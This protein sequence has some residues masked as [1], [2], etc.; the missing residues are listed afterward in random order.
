MSNGWGFAAL[1][2]ERGRLVEVI[3]DDIGLLESQHDLID[4]IDPENR[5]KFERFVSTTLMRQAAFDWSINVATSSGI[6]PLHFGAG[7]H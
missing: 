3:R 2:D 4:T 5:E 1:C 6:R 7:V